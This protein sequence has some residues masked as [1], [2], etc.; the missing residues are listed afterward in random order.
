MSEL[1]RSIA[2]GAAWNVLLKLLERSIGLVSTL[3]LARLLVPADFGLMAMATTVVAAL[4]LLG[5]Y[6]FD[7]ALVQNQKAGRSHYN[8]A[9]TL[10]V[11]IA[12]AKAILMV[13]LAF[14]AAAFYDEPRLAW[15]MLA[16]AVSTAYQGFEN[17]GIVAFQK[18]LRFDR[19]FKLALIRR[20]S[21]FVA[22]AV[23]AWLLQS[24][25]A[26]VIGISVTRL[27]SLC[28]TYRMHPYRPRW[29]LSR[30]GELFGYSKW[31][32]MNN[33]LG[34]LN[35]RGVDLLIGRTHGPAALGL[36][37]VSNEL[38]S[39]PT[40]EL[41][42]PIQR[43][44]FPGYARLAESG[45]ELRTT[46]IQVIGVLSLVT[47]P[48]ALFLGALAEPFVRAVLGSKW[49]DA[50]PLLQALAVFG[51][52][53]AMDGPASSIYLAL[54]KPRYMFNLQALQLVV[55]FAFL[56]WL[57]PAYGVIGA[58]WALIA[59]AAASLAANYLL[60]LRVLGLQWRRLADA[61]WRPV[62]SA[63]LVSVLMLWTLDLV[64]PVSPGLQTLTAAAL[65]VALGTLGTLL[66][67]AMLLG[68]WV[69]QGRPAHSA[70]ALV[71][72]MIRRNLPS[73]W[74]GDMPA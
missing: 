29:D 18:E 22:T 26:L 49:M 65:L 71:L 6:S 33:L 8:T 12:M 54:G 11:L 70:E 67:S 60:V 55:C 51:A 4:E 35:N 25:W 66:Y 63:V 17:I 2:R 59:G 38:A 62:V 40:S 69:L 43:A 23:S 36:Y 14:P 20:L 61:L 47:L 13:A 28:L 42:Y 37:S 48:A 19:E 73:R 1:K 52:V 39:M 56:A 44:V 9:W 32:L 30:T 21:G 34:F 3:L 10:G 24:Y 7:M 68:A 50:V 45:E 41:V 5:A 27:V 15:V 53:R 57:L 72:A 64:P 16:L 46:F 31:L 74:R 58:A